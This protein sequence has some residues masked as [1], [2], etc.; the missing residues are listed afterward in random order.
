ML[1]SQKT[2]K[3]KNKET[4][5]IREHKRNQVDKEK[6]INKRNQGNPIRG[7]DRNKD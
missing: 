6:S 4:H 3:Q 2:H 1:N 7:N 5:N